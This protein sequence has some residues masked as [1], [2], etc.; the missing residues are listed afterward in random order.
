MRCQTLPPELPD[1]IDLMIEVCYHRTHAAGV[2]DGLNLFTDAYLAPSLDDEDDVIKFK[3]R[4][5]V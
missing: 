2:M 5:C 4:V 3:V 1:D